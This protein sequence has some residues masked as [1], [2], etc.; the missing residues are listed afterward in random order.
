ME[1]NKELARELVKIKA[2]QINPNKFFTWTSGIKSPIYCDNRMTMSYPKV[3][4]KIVNAFK[5]FIE[6]MEEQPEVIAGCATAGIPHAAWLAEALDLPM[7][8]VRGKAKGHGKGNQIEGDLREGQ[9]V[10]VIED[11]ISTGG[12]SIEAAKSL[13]KS[14]AEVLGVLAIFTY[15]LAI[16]SE[17]F[18]K[19]KIYLHTITNFDSLVDL[20][21]EDGEL[22][23][24]KKAGLLEWRNQL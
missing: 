7:V 16:A 21:V 17:N 23:P 11:L 9:R 14:G 13:E 8:Y 18:K 6:N 10:I 2:V 22:P 15:G 4:K 5:Q 3:R 1:V 12:S 19:E 24:E 20:L